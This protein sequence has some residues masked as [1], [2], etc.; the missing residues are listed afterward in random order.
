MGLLFY[1]RAEF[2]CFRLLYPKYF[3]VSKQFTVTKQK[4]SQNSRSSSFSPM[5]GEGTHAS[6]YKIPKN[7][8][9][10]S[11]V[12]RRIW[13]VPG[14]QTNNTKSPFVIVH[15]P[16][17]YVPQLIWWLHMICY[18]KDPYYETN[19]RSRQQVVQSNCPIDDLFQKAQ[20]LGSAWIWCRHIIP[21]RGDNPSAAPAS[22]A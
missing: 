18:N 5:G 3:E 12:Y 19:K 22:S 1:F 2:E 10:S 21:L 9:C 7:H 13:W 17:G 4:L 20:R 15:T 16:A 8:F 11:L 6:S 14:L